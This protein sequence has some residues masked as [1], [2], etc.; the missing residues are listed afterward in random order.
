MTIETSAPEITREDEGLFQECAANI[1][2]NLNKAIDRQKEP[3]NK[4]SQLLTMKWYIENNLE[5][6]TN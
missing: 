5:E 3:P 1:L 2:K 4:I 6:E